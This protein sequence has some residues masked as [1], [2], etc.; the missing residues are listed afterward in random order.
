MRFE[1]PLWEACGEVDNA[2]ERLEPCRGGHWM[3]AAQTEGDDY[4][5]VTEKGRD[6]SWDHSGKRSGV[7][8][9]RDCQE[10]TP[11]LSES[12]LLCNPS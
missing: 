4:C 11:K 1:Q 5:W 2:L 7:S 8:G 6:F 9:K 10:G 12:F 3:V